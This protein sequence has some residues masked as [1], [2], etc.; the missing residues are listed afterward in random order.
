M[1]LRWF[2]AES[3]GSSLRVHGPEVALVSRHCDEEPWRRS[4]KRF[5]R[6]RDHAR[7]DGRARALGS[8]VLSDA[9]VPEPCRCYCH[10]EAHRVALGLLRSTS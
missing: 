3:M 10:S 5:R 4:R 6:S 1:R 7:C 8:A 2:T 9:G